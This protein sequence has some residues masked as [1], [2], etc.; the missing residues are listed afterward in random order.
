MVGGPVA[1]TRRPGH[2]VRRDFSLAFVLAVAQFGL[3]ILV[4]FEAA[5]WTTGRA[6]GRA[7][8]QIQ[9]PFPVAPDRPTGLAELSPVDDKQRQEGQRYG[10]EINRDLIRN[11]ETDGR[12]R[13]DA[14]Q[15]KEGPVEMDPGQKGTQGEEQ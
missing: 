7:S 10:H 2:L 12:G 14:A 9:P 6:A 11:A 4:I 15:E 1:G 5:K 3:H 13:E 8:P